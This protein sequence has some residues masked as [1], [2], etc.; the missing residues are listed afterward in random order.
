MKKIILILLITSLLVLSGCD[1]ISSATDKIPSK[2]PGIKNEEKQT[3]FGGSGSIQASIVNPQKG[4][5]VLK[6][7]PFQPVVRI[8]NLGGSEADGQICITGLDQDVFSGF[9]G[10]ECLNYQQI[11]RD[12]LFEDIDLK[13]GSYNIQTEESKSYALT[14]IN[15][16]KY[17]TTIKADVCITA[18]IYEDQKCGAN[19]NSVT[20]GPFRV[21]S[22]EETII[23]INDN[24]VTI[25][26]ELDID[27]VGSGNLWDL[28]R[29]N[30]MCVPFKSINEDK[31]KIKADIIRFPVSADL[32]CQDSKL[33]E[34]GETSI[35]CEAKQVSLF[36]NQG[37]SLFSKDYKPEVT[38]KLEYAYETRN[39]N[40]FN[41][42]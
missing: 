27:N 9:S 15:R 3:S 11:K 8:K 12:D 24:V 18:D 38:F 36:D 32:Q 21:S 23:P 42:A 19:I 14:A 4:A 10:C 41:L 40:T 7:Y 37:V 33:D 16:F 29:I 22:I 28:N 5:S 17:S 34:D 2:L 20:S 35:T 13:F 39:S 30:E 26:F 31:K 1:L 25:I 6:A